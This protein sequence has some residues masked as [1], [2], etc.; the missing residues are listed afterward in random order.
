MSRAEFRMTVPA[1]FRLKGVAKSHGWYDLPPFE[2]H[3]DDGRLV[4]IGLID[5]A[6]VA[7]TITQPAP[8]EIVARGERN[9]RW[10][11]ARQA[12]LE[13]MVCH[14]LGLDLD[15][16]EFF[17][18]GGADYR[19]ARRHGAGRLLRSTSVFEDA[20]KMLATTNCSWSLT[21]QMIRRL[22]DALGVPAPGGGKSFP[23]PAAMAARPVSFYRDEVRAGYRA[24]FFHAF[25]AA[26]AEGRIDPESWAEFPGTHAAL[27]R[28]IQAAQ[29]FGRYAAENL[30]KLLG[31]HDGFGLDSWCLKK[32]PMLF[33]PIRGDVI[34]HIE[35]RYAPFGRWR[36]L[37]LWL[38]LT[39]DWHERSAEAD[40][41][42]K[43][44]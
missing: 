24:P 14:I 18:L 15:L 9:G 43:F 36:G 17:R 2:W 13:S 3:E 37:A 20:V 8:R 38:D 28:E 32:Y 30:C 22:V 42:T 11:A 16:A 5:G 41:L 19:W 31:R 35:R 26:V 25:A 6:P 10:T 21:R 7:L 23:T 27:C 29:G 34:R 12:T 1:D 33:G 39:R 4:T 44:Q 40:P